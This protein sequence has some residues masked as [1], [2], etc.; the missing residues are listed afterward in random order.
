M[1]DGRFLFSIPT[2]SVFNACVVFSAILPN[3]AL[4]L[5]SGLALSSSYTG[6]KVNEFSKVT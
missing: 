3:P 1:G 2:P 6:E 5:T 4:T